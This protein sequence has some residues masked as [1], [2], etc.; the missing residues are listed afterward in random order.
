MGA[1]ALLEINTQRSTQ[2]SGNL[3]IGG[4]GDTQ[5]TS[6]GSQNYIKK[7]CKKSRVAR[8]IARHH[9]R[10]CGSM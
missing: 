3:A 8:L 4:T 6:I 5:C 7:V 1:P 2:S 9:D 10:T